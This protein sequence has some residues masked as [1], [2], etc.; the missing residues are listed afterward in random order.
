MKF[1]L[2]LNCQESSEDASFRPSQIAKQGTNRDGKLLEGWQLCRVPVKLK[3]GRGGEEDCQNERAGFSVPKP[4]V[5]SFLPSFL[6]VQFD[7]E[8]N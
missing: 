5:P 1:E 7:Q 2:K 3:R 6:P 8:F 4:F